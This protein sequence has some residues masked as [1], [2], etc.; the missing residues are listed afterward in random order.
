MLIIRSGN[1]NKR[2]PRKYWKRGIINNVLNSKDGIV[3]RVAVQL[4]NNVEENHVV[5][6]W[7]QKR[8]R[9]TRKRFRE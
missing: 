7:E 9:T 8:G 6:K 1:G 5:K 3:R 4:P 2:A